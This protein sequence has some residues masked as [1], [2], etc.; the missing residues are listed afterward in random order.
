MK[1]ITGFTLIEVLTSA[2]IV[3]L[4]VAILSFVFNMSLK[5]Y[6][7]AEEIIDITNRAQRVFSQICSE[8]QGAVVSQSPKIPFVGTSTSINFMAPWENSTKI[9]LCEFGYRYSGT[10]L[11]K[12]FIKFGVGNYQYPSDVVF[13][14]ANW[15]NCVEQIDSVV[16]KYSGDGTTWPDNWDSNSHS[17]NLPNLVEISI[18]INDKAGGARI[19]TTR[20]FIPS[21]TNS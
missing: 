21:S 18:T 4:L 15:Y 9:E 12:R 19:F 5:A 10:T 1:K 11:Q 2:F 8:L 14:D 7:Q 20:V 3:A 13:E 17:G 6:R 16:F